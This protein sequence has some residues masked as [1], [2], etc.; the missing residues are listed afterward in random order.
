M[1]AFA[2]AKVDMVFCLGDLTDHAPGDSEADVR[3]NF[4]EIMDLLQAYPFPFY[5]VP[6]N[7]D[8]L[9]M[10]GEEL[11]E[12]GNLPLPPYTVTAGGMDFIVLDANYRWDMRRFDR[13]GVEWTD[14]NLPP[15]QMDYLRCALKNAD[16]D[17]VILLHENI[18]PAVE[19]HHIVHNAD[20]IRALIASSPRV[21]LV[22]Q[23]HYHPG[24]ENVYQGIR[25]LTLP[26]MCEGTRNPYRILDTESLHV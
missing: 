14:A 6:G 1:E 3:E 17:C 21:K 22:L 19:A 11:A 2:Q 25:Y 16:K 5:L 13:A 23:G 10:T 24:A 15:E 8:Y 20:E 7:H 18:D 9:M 26:A 4:R 12:L